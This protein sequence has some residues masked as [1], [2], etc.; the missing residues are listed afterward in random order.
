[1][2]TKLRVLGGLVAAAAVCTASGA[3]SP[4]KAGASSL[5]ARGGSMTCAAV[6]G[7]M[8]FSPPM[9]LSVPGG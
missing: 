3:P 5:V 7:R 6:S 8:S 4:A 2:K 1:M 9:R